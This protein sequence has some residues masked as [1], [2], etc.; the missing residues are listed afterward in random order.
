[1]YKRI[2][3]SS[4]LMICSYLAFCQQKTSKPNFIVILTDDQTYRAIGYNNALVKTPHLN[5]LA[6][7]GIIF[8]RAI[9]A[10]PICAASRASLL[11]GL[12]PQTNGTV[13][14]NT[15]TF[16]TNIV[17]QH[18][19]KTLAN[20]LNDAGYSTFFCGKSHLGNPKDY[21]F[22]FGEESKDFTDVTTFK[23][24]AD[25]INDN[26]FGDKPFLLWLAAKQ[27]HVPLKPDQ[28]W[29]DLYT[30]TSLPVEPNFQERP[31]RES[32]YNQG[33]P[34]ENF[35]RDADYTDNYKNLPSGPPRTAETIKEFTQAYY[36]T[37]SHLDEQL[38]TIIDLL[39]VTGHLKKTIIIFLSDNGYF[40]GNHGLGNKITMQEESVRVPFF[41]SWD[42]LKNQGKHYDGVIS[43]VD[44]LPTILD[45]A[46]VTAPAY[47]HGKSLKAI[48]LNTDPGKRNNFAVSEC[49]GVGGGLGIGH[50]MVRTK[51]WKYIL[52]DNNDEALFDLKNDPYEMKNLIALPEHHLVLSELKQ[53]LKNW[54]VLVGD[55][56]K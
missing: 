11:T 14:L 35:Y 31:P 49:T 53:D 9:A 3:V 13:A 51:D 43:S 22:Q 46:G 30:N 32:F 21:G 20:Y 26:S 6:H 18:Q 7:Q 56:K 5:Q 37:I 1:M 41:I 29:L 33:L 44:V 8:D 55:K 34:G 38:G 48:L 52:S 19:Y 10:T 16:I 2:F 50:R 27:P 47:L 24:A 54:Q 42:K 17:K 23:K 36:A 40:L 28:K 15:N 12:Y 39:R 45:L 4:I 25:F